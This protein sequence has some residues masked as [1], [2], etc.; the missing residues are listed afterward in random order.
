VLINVHGGHFEGGSRIAS[1]LES[2]PIAVVGKIKV[3]SIDYRMAPEYTFPA[4]SED[5]AAVYRELLKTYKPQNIG[6][7]GSSAGGLLAAESIA[8]FDKHALPLPGAVG[9]LAGAATYYQEGDSGRI[10]TAIEGSPLE[11]P[12]PVHPYFKGTDPANALAFPSRSPELM[13]KFPPSLLIASTRDITLSSVA[14]TH[15]Q[16]VRLGVEAELHVWD[17]LGHVFYFDPSL[18]ESREVYDVIIHFFQRHL[19]QPLKAQGV[20]P[21]GKR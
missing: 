12:P 1:H 7:Y 6:L 5:V 9:M 2:I 14:Y 4:A 16:L 17:G 8:W 19:G 18:P 20:A 15:G 11:L 10:V 3:I 21:E 13:A